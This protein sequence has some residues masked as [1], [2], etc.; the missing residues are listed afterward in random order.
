MSEAE[1]VAIDE[2]TPW[3]ENPRINDGAVKTVADSITR[4]GW[5]SPILCRGDGVVIAGHTRLKAAQELGLDKVLVRYMDLDPAT[6]KALALADNKL[7]EIADWDDGALAQILIDLDSQDLDL[8]GLGWSEEELDAILDQPEE[9]G[10]YDEGRV[11]DVQADVVSKSGEVYQLGPHRLICGDCR[12]PK[13]IES[14]LGGV[15]V[16]VAFT[17][18]PY[19]SQRKY[20]ELSGFKPI[21]PDD[22]G[23]W[24]EAV[25]A[26]VKTHLADDGSWFVNIKEHCEDGQRHLYVKDLTI[27]HVRRWGWRFVDELCWRHTG[28]PGEVFDRFRNGWEPIFHFSGQERAKC[29]PQNVA[30]PSGSVIKYE[31]AHREAM[32]HD[33]NTKGG[34]KR[35]PGMAYPRNVIDAPNGASTSIAGHSATFPIALPEFFIKAY[36]DKG[37]AIFD[38][39]MGSGTTQIA[40]AK[41]GRVA[42]GC[43]ISPQYCDVIRRRWTRW[44]VA[45]NQD[46]GPGALDE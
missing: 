7:G 12:D 33:P 19:A 24:F 8:S 31:S 5:G 17:S 28:F 29:R 9:G 21:P 11:P 38:P 18:P 36:S 3:D 34:A 1:W 42:Y 26:N 16:N 37:D 27:A 4:F 46:P 43:E 32:T 45:N 40:A 15:S 25:Q 10:E 13:V 23:D 2:V 20:D 22:Y 14:L 44:A 6:A 35:S 41:N 39:F 30:Y